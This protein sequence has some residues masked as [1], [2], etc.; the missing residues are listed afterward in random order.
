MRSTSPR[1]CGP[2]RSRSVFFGKRLANRLLLGRTFEKVDTGSR[3]PRSGGEG[4]RGARL[5]ERGAAGGPRVPPERHRAGRHAAAN[6]N[7][8][9]RND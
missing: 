6:F 5:R 9:T 7:F 3:G 4:R 8:I 2:S 1:G